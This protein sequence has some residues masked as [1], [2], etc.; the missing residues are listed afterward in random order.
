MQ[1]KMS[2]VQVLQKI[3]QLLGKPDN[4][5]L[6]SLE[7]MEILKRIEEGFSKL[8]DEVVRYKDQLEESSIMLE[9]QV[10]E[11]SKTYEELST[12]YDVTG[13]LFRSLDPV[14]ELPGL[15]ELILNSVPS[16]AIGVVV[17][18]PDKT[19]FEVRSAP[20][21][22]LPFPEKE[23]LRQLEQFILNQKAST[24]LLEQQDISRRFPELE[25]KVTSLTV[26]P[27][28]I[29]ENLWGAMMLANRQEASLFTAGDRKL[30][31]S[32]AN[33]LFF[34]LENFRYLQEKIEQERVFEQLKI[35]KQIQSSF[36]PAEIPPF[37][38]TDISA[39]FSPAIDVA[40]DYYDVIRMEERLYLI[41]ADVS[42][43]GIPAS[44][45]MSSFR[46]AVRILL[47]NVESLPDLVAQVN[48][49][50]AANDIS[51][52]FVTAIFISLDSR[53][54]LMKFVNAGHDPILL[55]RPAEERFFEIS[56]DGIPTGIFEDETFRE[57]SFELADGDVFVMY[58]DGIP[59]A[60]NTKREEFGFE[61]LK[62]VIQRNY[63]RD[64]EQIK[65]QIL[66]ELVDFVGDA[67]QHDDTTFI[68][69]KYTRNEN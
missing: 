6:E 61:R 31:E 51:D 55:F 21:T 25:G 54:N 66:K 13:L 23:I 8:Q 65:Q 60:R 16:Q 42:G 29:K 24:I 53:D 5:D 69:V 57:D 4:P 32:I 9:T 36:L 41:V 15:M 64:A 7:D 18:L 48:D 14:E 22:D 30:L 27:I 10:E 39:S 52:R 37:Q 45:L 20:R 43:K 38:G 35:A 59:E 47:P 67:P 34:S 19:V 68:V 11:I 33:Q 44:L 46:T 12:L 58:T 49:H 1:D 56:N 17:N 2:L 28:G 40:G 3:E 63:F 26:V 50:L 62:D